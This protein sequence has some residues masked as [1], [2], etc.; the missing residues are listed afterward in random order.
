[1]DLFLARVSYPP[2]NQLKKKE[3]SEFG[4][5]WTWLGRLTP[6]EKQL[7][8]AYRCSGGAAILAPVGRGMMA[9]WAD[10]APHW[11]PRALESERNKTRRKFRVHPVQYLDL[12]KWGDWGPGEVTCQRW[13]SNSVTETGLEPR[14]PDS[15]DGGI[16]LNSPRR[17]WITKNGVVGSIVELFLTLCDPMDCSMPRFPV[18]HQLPELAQSH[19]HW[20]GDA[21]QPSHLLL[22][23]SPPLNLFQHQGLFQWVS[24]SHQMAKVLELQL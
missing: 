14:A 3:D 21:I 23:P 6:Q 11:A 22:S 19:A 10:C 20:V 8:A 24:S 17:F 4:R 5:W 18:H 16:F 2:L 15:Q 7:T 9:A 1:M 12:A 13:N